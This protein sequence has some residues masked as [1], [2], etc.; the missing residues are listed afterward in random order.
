MRSMNNTSHHFF[1]HQLK[2]VFSILQY[3]ILFKPGKL[4]QFYK[5]NAPDLNN[6]MLL[7]DMHVDSLAGL[8]HF[9]YQQLYM[10]IPIEGAGCIEHYE[11]DGS[12]L[13]INAKIADSIKSDA[14][15]KIAP[16]EAVGSLISILDDDEG[17]DFA[18][19]NDDWE[20]QIRL[21]QADSSATWF[22]VPELI[23]AIDTLKDIHLVIPGSRYKLAYKIPITTIAPEFETFNYYI[24]AQNGSILKVLST[25]IYDGPA[26]VYGYGS[27]TIDT[28]W[29][30]GFTQ[31]HILQTNNATRVIHTKKNPSGTTAWA[32]LDNTKDD[33]DDWGSTYLTET[34]THYHV[35]NSWD[36][37]RNTFARTGQNNMSIEIRVRTQWS[38]ANAR[39]TT[40]NGH[41]DLT[42]GK[43]SGVDWGLD[44][45]IV[46]H[47]YTHGVTAHTSNLGVTY[48]SG[49]LNESF[50]DIFGIV[51]QATT[52]D[53]GLTDWIWGNFI[54]G[55][56]SRS[57]IN[58]NNT[59]QPDT[60]SGSLWYTGSLDAGGVHVNCGVQ[61]KWFYILAGGEY[62]TNDLSN[63]YD[64]HGIGINK[65]ARISYYALT[66]IL[67]SSSQF[68]DSR[69]ATVEAAKILYGECSI[70]HQSTI[71]SW[72]A[73]GIGSENTCTY[74]LG[75]SEAIANDL[76]IYP[77][78]ADQFLNIE[79][80]YSTTEKIRMY[81]VSGKLV[82]EFN[83]ENRI[84]Q[85]D[86]HSFDSGMYTI[87]FSFDGR[88]VIK[89][90]IIQK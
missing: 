11:T 32:F 25:S 13:F 29:K 4:Y 63:Y 40:G 60:Y 62:G 24:D 67:M 89:R 55:V 36:Y 5:T 3:Q 44:P 64:V 27:R 22:P 59:S 73:V 72:Y 85:L 9:K 15:P 90:F 81:D 84:F 66:S 88:T 47:E 39:F 48:E 26:D 53:G 70:E 18:W 56:P 52:L 58:P 38:Q 68:S 21:D 2:V 42:F 30:G 65:A 76:L 35:S 86:I 16:K 79:L 82:K 80:P 78:P 31:K 49:A 61:N 19:E 6:D 14:T 10:N 71:D 17:I 57:L 74:T 12:L 28:Q 46:G 50:S 33:D 87:Q 41:N 75:I 37:F 45:S 43:V 7:T 77:N 23:W 8:T 51:I 20:Q 83:N 34:S 69:E 1:H 54:S